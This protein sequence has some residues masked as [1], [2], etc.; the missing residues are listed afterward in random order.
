MSLAWVRSHWVLVDRELRPLASIIQCVALAIKIRV[1]VWPRLPYFRRLVPLVKL[2]VII[3]IAKFGYRLF[4]K[5]RLK[6]IGRA[7]SLFN[8]GVVLPP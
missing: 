7:T 3:Q 8:R 5:Y 4:A 6:L 1:L 2:P